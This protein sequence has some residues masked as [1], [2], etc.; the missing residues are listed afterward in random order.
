MNFTGERVVPSDMERNV[1]TY[2]QHLVRYVWALPHVA[3]KKV[4]DAACGTGY[5]AKLMEDV[6][7]EVVG[8]DV[9]LDALGYARLYNKTKGGFFRHDL[10]KNLPEVKFDL[11]S[12][13]ET[14]E[15]LDDPK[16]FLTW[17]RES[18]K[19]TLGSIPINCPGEYHKHV[20]GSGQILDLLKEVFGDVALWH[21]EEMNIVE[22]DERRLIKPCGMIIFLAVN[23]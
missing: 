14:I 3:G 7:S 1:D 6:A 8:W 9:D 4:L 19:R 13:F 23:H 16:R 5:G 11:I 21:Q 15:H 20:Y 12:S 17:C 18:S 22:I 2:Q 10:N